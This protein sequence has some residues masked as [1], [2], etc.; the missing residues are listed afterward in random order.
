M[1]WKRKDIIKLEERL[2]PFISLSVKD[3]DLDLL[4]SS[5]YVWNYKLL[6]DKSAKNRNRAKST[7]RSETWKDILQ[8]SQ[9]AS[10]L[11]PWHCGAGKEKVGYP[12]RDACGLDGGALRYPAL[13]DVLSRATWCPYCSTQISYF[14]A[15]HESQVP[16]V[17]VGLAAGNWVCELS[18]KGWG[19]VAT[20]IGST[21]VRMMAMMGTLP[22]LTQHYHL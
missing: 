4:S 3:M 2:N 18:W 20:M 8:A 1:P 10:G 12:G 11:L 19:G 16:E 14:P 7:T 13:Y 9:A 15:L 21:L 17:W 22:Y 6:C 5:V